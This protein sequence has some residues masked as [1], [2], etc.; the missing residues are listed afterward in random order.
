MLSLTPPQVT[1]IMARQRFLEQI[2]DVEYTCF[3]QK[4]TMVEFF[5]INLWNYLKINPELVEGSEE[6]IVT[7][8]K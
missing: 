5:Q 6:I 1:Q 7:N 3:A 4:C 2:A 8:N